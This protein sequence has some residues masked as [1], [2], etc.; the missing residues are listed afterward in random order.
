MTEFDTLPAIVVCNENRKK[1][2]LLANYPIKL[3]SYP[4]H[5]P[6]IY[7]MA[8]E[9]V[10]GQKTEEQ[11]EATEPEKI[12]EA[13]ALVAEDNS[14]NQK[15]IDMMLKEL[16]INADIAGNGQEAMQKT[17]QNSYDIIFMDISMPVLDGV[18]ATRQIVE[19]E[20]ANK[21][22]HTPIVA[23]TAHALKGDRQTFLAAGMDD[24]LAK[25]IDMASLK[26]VLAKYLT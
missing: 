16:G 17:S 4:F 15:L 12:F 18:Q 25:P 23:L 6:E 3:I 9:I 24:Y 10:H 20:K 26:S 5:G 11:K 2:A 22:P 13:R 7:N 21:K 14:V 1:A 19:Y 8:M